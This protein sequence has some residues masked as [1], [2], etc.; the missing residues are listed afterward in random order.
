VL[1]PFPIRCLTFWFV[2]WSVNGPRSS[3]QKDLGQNVKGAW[4]ISHKVPALQ[5]YG[6]HYL[7]QGPCLFWFVPWSVNGPRS[8]L[9]RDLGQNVKGA[10][11][12]SHK[13]PVLQ[14]YGPGYLRPGDHVCSGL[15]L[16]QLMAPGDFYK[17]T[18]SHCQMCLVYFP[19][20]ACPETLWIRLLKA[21]DHAVLFP[22]QL[23]V[24]GH[25][26]KRI[27]SGS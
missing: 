23:L 12:I 17:R 16:G 20:G 26:Q 4:S 6:P 3:L 10:W 8:S 7:W 18:W 22:G 1:G 5:C 13:V 9:Q 25:L 11:S 2:P 27:W 19:Q 24:P 21:G 14:L 15:F